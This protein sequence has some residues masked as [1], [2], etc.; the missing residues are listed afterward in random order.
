MSISFITHVHY[1][2]VQK[3]SKARENTKLVEEV[4]D[5]VREINQMGI[6][7]I[8]VE[9]NVTETLQMCDYAYVI[10]N[11]ATVIDGTGAGMLDIEEIRSAYLGL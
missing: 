7:V 6:T 1:N 4:F 5:F 11:G 2:T 3:E 10:K 8:I 9:Q